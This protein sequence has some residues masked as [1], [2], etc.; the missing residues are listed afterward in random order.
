[1]LLLEW[2]AS[3]IVKIAQAALAMNPTIP[4][5]SGTGTRERRPRADAARLL[6]TFDDV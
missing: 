3:T 5:I 4:R 1:V 2:L 6:A